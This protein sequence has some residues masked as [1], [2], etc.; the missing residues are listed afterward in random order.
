MQLE[1]ILP[2]R[3]PFLLID[4][5]LNFEENKQLVAIKNVTINEPFFS[6]HFP[7][8]PVMPGVLIL[9][10]MAQAAIILYAQ[11]KHIRKNEVNYYFAKVDV[12]FKKSVVPGDQVRIEIEAEKMLTKM[13]I[14]KATASVSGDIV[15]QGRIAFSIQKTEK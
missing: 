12:K 14:T 10:A 11:S 15:A 2:Q 9:E 7:N 13:A 3:Y 8:L 5:V 1:K 6:G 4:R